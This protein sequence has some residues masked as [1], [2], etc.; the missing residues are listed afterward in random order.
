MALPSVIV[1]TAS[2][3]C[4]ASPYHSVT[5]VMGRQKS[6][7]VGR[8]QALASERLA[9]LLFFFFLCKFIVVIHTRKAIVIERKNIHEQWLLLHDNIS[10]LSA[11]A[12]IIAVIIYSNVMEVVATYPSQYSLLKKFWLIHTLHIK[13]IDMQQ[14]LY[15][16]LQ[17]N[18][19]THWLMLSVVKSSVPCS[20]KNS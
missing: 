11:I 16:I 3:L 2:L 18:S 13:T 19:L 6:N 14:G 8:K 15:V 5:I 1:R 4:K 20:T 10:H 17:I 7:V 12:Y 9:L